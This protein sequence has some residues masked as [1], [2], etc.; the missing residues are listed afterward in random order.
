MP[1]ARGACGTDGASDL[2][3]EEPVEDRDQDHN[4]QRRHKDRVLIK[5]DS[6]YITERH[7]KIILI[8]TDGLICLTAHNTEVDGVETKLGQDSRKDRRDP[9]RRVKDS[10]HKARDHSRDKRRKQGHS[11]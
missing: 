1:W 8:H 3:S 6:L 4:D 2:R 10:G 5:S 7:Q 11:H 9:H